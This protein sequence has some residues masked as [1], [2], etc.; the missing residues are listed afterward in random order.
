MRIHYIQN[1]PLATLGFI[2]EWVQEK[3]NHSSFARMFE[4]EPL[5]CMDQFDMLI[6][7]G[8][9]MGAYEEEEYPWLVEE[10]KFILEAIAQ[11]KWILGI[12]LGAQLLANV[13]GSKVYPHTHQEIGWWPIE[14]MDEAKTSSL[15]D[16][17]PVSFSAFEYH[18][19]TFDLPKKA[20]RLASSKGC[21]NQAFS[22]GERVIGLQFHAEFTGDIICGLEKKFGNQ[23]PSGLYTQKPADWVNQV[24][25][26]DGAK[27]V[28]FTVLTNMEAGILKMK[29]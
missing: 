1:D 17:I 28:L 11:E 22:Y 12:C 14:V 3:G 10:K 7:L 16:G 5:P 26:L 23:M 2:E 9:R 4:D 20:I 8:G 13:L 6:I 18:G 19:D 25:L 27:T 29:V 21:S 15:F 24:D